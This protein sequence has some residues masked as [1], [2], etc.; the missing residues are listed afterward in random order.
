M[1][2][3]NIEAPFEKIAVDVVGAFPQSDQGNRYE[4][5][6]IAMDYFT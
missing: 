5:L 2:Q 4:Y 3:Y 6:V 1:H